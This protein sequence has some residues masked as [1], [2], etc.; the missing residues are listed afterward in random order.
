MAYKG[1]LDVESTILKIQ[2]ESGTSTVGAPEGK[3]LR[4]TFNPG[5]K[6]ILISLGVFSKDANHT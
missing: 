1:L 4:G 2:C 3:Q 5:E 6:G